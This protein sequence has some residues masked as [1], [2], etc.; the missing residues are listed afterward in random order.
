MKIGLGVL[1]GGSPEWLAKTHNVSEQQVEQSWHLCREAL[2][3]HFANVAGHEFKLLNDNELR[4]RLEDTLRLLMDWRAQQ[5][6]HERLIEFTKPQDDSVEDTAPID[7]ND[8][9]V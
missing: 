7:K 4:E 1:D 8:D 5:L 2:S 9:T 6:Q 3:K